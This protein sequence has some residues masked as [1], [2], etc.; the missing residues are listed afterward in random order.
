[1]FVVVVVCVGEMNEMELALSPPLSGKGELE[2]D[3]DDQP[4]T[5]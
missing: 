2:R 3:V 1:M 5:S 4:D